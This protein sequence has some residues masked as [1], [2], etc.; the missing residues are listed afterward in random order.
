MEKRPNY[1][2]KKPFGAAYFKWGACLGKSWM[3]FPNFECV[4]DF[5]HNDLGCGSI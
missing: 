3:W 1:V 5:K 2:F 4:I